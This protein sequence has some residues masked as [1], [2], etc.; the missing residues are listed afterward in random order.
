VSI[1]GVDY[2]WG[3]PGVAAL[4]A[5]GVRF[6]CRYLSHDTSGKNLS[7]TEAKQLSDA[8][9]WIVVVW[10]TTAN[11]ALSG[12]TGGAADAR[13]AARQARACG[14]PGGRPIY[15]AVDWDVQPSQIPTVMA[16]LAGAATV[17]G[18]GGTGVYGGY[19]AVQAAL[20]GNQCAWGW[21]T[22]A[23]SGGRWDSRAQIQQYSN[24][25]KINGVGLDFDRAVVT[26]Y[27]Q[28]RVGVSPSGEDDMPEPKD[29]WNWDGIPAPP[30]KAADNKNW[31]PASYLHWLYRNLAKVAAKQD[32]QAVTIDKLV[33]A[34]AAGPGLDAAALKQ[35]IRAAIESIDV[36][37]DVPDEDVNAEDGATG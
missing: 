18:K 16:Y 36:K 35:E 24:D 21:Q 5:S 26:D 25:R 28:W 27:G 8:G 7:L 13:E 15:F 29:L 6:A 20:S 12:R 9:I 22:Y 1:F 11:R 3:R 4:K 23:W 10:E 32:A 19:R 37:L 30:W 14:M 33:D 17:L 31:T 34:I 2:A